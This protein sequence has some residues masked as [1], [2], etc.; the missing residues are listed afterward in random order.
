[1]GTRVPESTSTAPAGDRRTLSLAERRIGSGWVAGAGVRWRTVGAV[2]LLHRR[3]R[4]RRTPRRRRGGQFGID[5][6]EPLTTIALAEVG[7]WTNVGT[8]AAVIAGAD[9]GVPPRG[10]VRTTCDAGSAVPFLRFA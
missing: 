4:E 5:T 3:C 10:V 6:V 7:A 8:F 2:T 1:M 9:P